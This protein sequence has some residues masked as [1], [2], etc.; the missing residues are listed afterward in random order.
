MQISSLLSLPS[1]SYSLFH[2]FF[3]FLSMH[4]FLRLCLC[5][6]I[7]LSLIQ[8]QPHFAHF[9]SPPLYPFSHFFIPVLSRC[10]SPS[11]SFSRSCT[12][13]H[14]YSFPLSQFIYLSLALPLS[15][16][17]SLSLSPLEEVTTVEQRAGCRCMQE[18]RQGEEG[19]FMCVCVG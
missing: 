6:R 14:A 5:H 12:L 4:P 10:F 15:L 7:H 1:F 11:F 17:L 18:K 2:P 19:M 8:S 13:S 9:L 3:L 16:S